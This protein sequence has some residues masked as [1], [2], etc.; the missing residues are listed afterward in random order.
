M[1]GVRKLAPRRKA[2]RTKAKRERSWSDKQLHVLNVGMFD[3]DVGV[4][5]NLSEA[6]IR[7]RLKPLKPEAVPDLEKEIR[8]WDRDRVAHVRGRMCK[9]LNGFLVL[10]EVGNDD[11][12]AAVGVIVHEMT[13]VAQYLLRARRIPLTE[14]TEEVHAYLAE[15]LV[16]ETLRRLY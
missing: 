15:W 11:F 13:H 7:A 14:D 6:E 3:V 10:L 16:R 1:A 8:D 4:A 5:V 2:A 12:R 9:I